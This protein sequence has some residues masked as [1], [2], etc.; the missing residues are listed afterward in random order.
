MYGHA[1][2][3][4]PRAT[5]IRACPAGPPRCGRAG[6]ALFHRSLGIDVDAGDAEIERWFLAAALF[7]TASRL[8]SRNE[9]SVCSATQAWHIS[10]RH[11]T[12]RWMTSS[13]SWMKAATRVTPD[14]AQGPVR[15]HRRAL[16]RAGRHDRPAVQHLPEL[17]AAPDVLPGW[18]PVTIQ[19]FLRELRGVWPG[20]ATAARPRASTP[21]TPRPPRPGPARLPQ[22]FSASP[23]W[24]PDVT[25]AA[26]TSK[27]AWSG[28]PWRITA[29]E[30]PMPGRAP[31]R[32][33]HLV[34]C[35]P[36]TDRV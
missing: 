14:A 27:A 21:Q 10:S 30:G 35:Q 33:V 32:P 8:R 25:P 28:S 12:Y 13:P 15:D 20:R 6:R 36:A 11:G 34:L 4:E 31:V 5:G 22:R 7:G 26:G 9:R 24:P 16:R 18:G 2:Q 23:S 1:G 3:R 17:R 19:L 29:G